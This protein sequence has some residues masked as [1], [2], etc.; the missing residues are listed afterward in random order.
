MYLLLRT[1]TCSGRFIFADRCKINCPSQSLQNLV[2]A[3]EL[4]MRAVVLIAID[5]LV[6]AWHHKA[7]P[8]IWGDVVA[9][10]SNAAI[11]HSNG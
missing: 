7:V 1:G 11:S 8:G 6:I 4:L 3:K 10:G 9:Q 5:R 2:Q